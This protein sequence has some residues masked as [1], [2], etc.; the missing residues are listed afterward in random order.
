M[1]K[2]TPEIDVS[3]EAAK[4]IARGM[5][6]LAAADGVHPK[7]LAMIEAFLADCYEVAGGKESHEEVLRQQFDMQQ[8]KEVLHT[9]ELRELF[10][11]SCLLLA[12]A[13]GVYSEAEQNLMDHYSMDLAIPAGRLRELEQ[14]VKGY[15]LS[16]F[17]GVKIFRDKA[18]ELGRKLGLS[19][20]AIERALQIRTE[21]LIAW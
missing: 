20:E 9:D 21:D 12:C 14:E 8:A 19:P 6:K 17:A 3:L 13:D 5:M 4:T 15:F 7:E 11:K 16:Q 10:L 2:F 18:E 1:N